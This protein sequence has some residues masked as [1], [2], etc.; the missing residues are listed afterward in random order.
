MSS[1]FHSGVGLSLN[2]TRHWDCFFEEAKQQDPENQVLSTKHFTRLSLFVHEN[3]GLSLAV[4]ILGLFCR[5]NRQQDFEN[6]E[7]RPD[8][9]QSNF[10]CP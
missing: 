10:L 5:G 3:I 7:F 2:D 6:Q 9:R 1:A 4:E 8:F